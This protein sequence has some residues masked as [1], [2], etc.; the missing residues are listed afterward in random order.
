[1]EILTDLQV[2]RFPES[3]NNIFSG[4]PVCVSLIS[5]GQKQIIAETSDLV[6]YIC[7]IRCLWTEFLVG[8]F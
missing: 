7:T 3:E 1:M 4:W 5:I 6:F 8:V 2:M